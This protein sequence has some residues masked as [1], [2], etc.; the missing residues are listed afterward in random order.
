[1]R[2]VVLTGCTTRCR[3]E[4]RPNDQSIQT[5]QSGHGQIDSN[6]RAYTCT[7]VTLLPST[8]EFHKIL[9]DGT[10]DLKGD[11]SGA[12]QANLIDAHTHAP[13]SSRFLMGA[14]GVRLE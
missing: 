10:L 8:H 5:Q 1:V 7:R 3:H 4:L 12:V 14:S 6:A 9:C 13:V 2:M 11:E